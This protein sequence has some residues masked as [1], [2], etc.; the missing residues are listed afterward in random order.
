MQFYRG[1]ELPY[2]IVTNSDGSTTII[3]HFTLKVSFQ[4]DHVY[5][6]KLKVK[7]PT[8]ESKIQIVTIMNPLKFDKPEA[9]TPIFF[10]F[11]PTILVDRKLQ[12]Q[13]DVLEEDK[14][15]NT[16]EVPL[17]GPVN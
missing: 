1:T 13:L 12:L 8:I 7:D 16:V 6:V 17:V 4:G 14:I 15:I 2:Q 5:K 3:N 9:K 11:D 10:K